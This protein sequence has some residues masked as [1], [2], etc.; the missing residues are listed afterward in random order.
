MNR[1][2]QTESWP[3]IPLLGE[4]E[5][6]TFLIPEVFSGSQSWRI[7][8]TTTPDPGARP[9]AVV[10]GAWF[11][12]EHLKFGLKGCLAASL[13]YIIYSALFWP[14]ISTSVTTCLLTALTTVGASRQKQVLRFGGAVLGGFV[15]GMGAQVFILPY[16]DSI[17]GFTALFVVVSII[18][19]WIITSSPRLSYLGVQ[20][21]FA[22]YLINL[23]EFRIQTSLGVARDRVVGILI[24][25]VVMWLVFDQLW[26]VPAAVAMRKEFASGLRL[27]AQLAREPVSNDLRIAIECSYSL[28]ERINAQ[29]DKVRS[30][31]DGV[32]FE[33]GSSRQ[34]DLELRSHFRKWQPQFRVLFLMRIAS[35][36]YRAQAPGFEF[37]RGVCV[38]QAAYDE[39][40]ARI[41]EELADCIE[42]GHLVIARG[43]GDSAELL[44]ATIEEAVAEV[45][46][47]LP[48]G[49]AQS[50]VTLMRGIDGL[51]KS[52]A[53]DIA[54]ELGGPVERC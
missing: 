2:D 17:A 6:T 3:G 15:I 54:A 41:L 45:P 44:K 27:L 26:S 11:T 43:P 53:S 19:A 18:A 12:P 42:R 9:S 48:D 40:S 33:F 30:L 23:Q 29:F 22:F 34:K 50:F 37:P 20:V 47:G 8:D 16:I 31:A 1:G 24:G 25:L 21:A 39:H 5:R 7:F 13:C 49:R 14:E 28:R 10:R 46:R 51:T 36:K 32:L 35:W 52:L 38:R 4:I